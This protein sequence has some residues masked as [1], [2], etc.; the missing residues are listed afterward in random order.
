MLILKK[1]PGC[2]F[3]N[4]ILALSTDEDREQKYS[5][6]LIISESNVTKHVSN[7]R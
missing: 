6:M 5:N 2:A 1:A 7:Y 4:V 3:V